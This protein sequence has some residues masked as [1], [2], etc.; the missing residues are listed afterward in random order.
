MRAVQSNATSGVCTGAQAAAAAALDGPADLIHDMVATYERRRNLMVSALRDI[1]GLSC[2]MPA[3]AF[4]VYPGIGT[5]LGRKTSSGRVLET[6]TDFALA[7]LDEAHVAT[8][9]GSAFGMAPYLRLSCATS[10]EAL[11]EA[12]AR[13]KRFIASLV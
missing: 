10:D 5:F 13:L 8:V 2:A 11:T 7:F 3:G 4:Y 9:P 6:D 1:P 12:C